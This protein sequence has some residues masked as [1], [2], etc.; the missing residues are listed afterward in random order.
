MFRIYASSKKVAHIG[1][2]TVDED[3]SVQK[4]WNRIAY[5]AQLNLP[6]A[7]AMSVYYSIASEGD[8]LKSQDDFAILSR[9]ASGN[10]IWKGTLR[11]LEVGRGY[12][13]KRTADSDATFYYPCYY[14]ESRYS[15]NRTAPQRTTL[16]ENNSATS[17]NIVA[18]VSGVDVQ[19]S[20][21]LVVF[22]GTSRIGMAEVSEDGLFYLNVAQPDDEPRRLTFCLERGGQVVSITGSV[23]CYSADAVIGSPEQPTDIS[24]TSATYD[25]S[26]GH[27]YTL[28]GTRLPRKPQRPGL[29]IHNGKVIN[30]K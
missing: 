14:S 3:I 18:C 22:N 10:F 11:Y 17:M 5:L 8:V 9:N 21:R 30:E 29:Y 15:G 20:D 13:L 24:F 27:W 2:R 1:G 28:D 23:Y 6:I 7:Q 26:D 19:D 4:G 16:L 12:M 25:Y